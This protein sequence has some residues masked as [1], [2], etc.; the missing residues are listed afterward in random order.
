M[1]LF[2][3][4]KS[5][6]N[7]KISKQQYIDEMHRVHACLFEYAEFLQ[8]TDI[9]KIEITDGRVVMESRATGIRILCDS[10]DKRIA[11]I[12]ILNFGNYEKIDSDMVFRLLEDKLNI[13]DIGANIGWYSINI[14]KAF[15]NS[16]VYSFE[17]VPATYK[18]LK[19]NIENNHIGNVIPSNFGFSDKSGELT[20]YFHPEGSGSASAA[21]LMGTGTAQRISCRVKRLDDF[22]SE[23]GNP[24]D[25]IKCD[26]EGAELFVLAGGAETI[27]KFKPVVFAEM[28]RKWTAKFNYHPN[29]IIEF[30]SKIGYRCFVNKGEYLVELF[31]VD[32]DTAETN[33]FFLHPLVHASKI[34][35]LTKCGK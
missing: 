1:K 29:Q 32:S 35:S 24:V 31:A 7:A 13:L 23:S 14:A 15:P 33:F 28:L 9:A 3:L 8:G 6:Q 17:P 2:E 16:Q 4:R 21:D 26:V 27:K 30:M 11:P 10:A 19:L 34:E 22:V 25:F 5:F 12:E 18:Y 20:F